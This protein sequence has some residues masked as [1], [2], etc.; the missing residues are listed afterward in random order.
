[1]LIPLMP[2]GLGLGS[3]FNLSV[4]DVKVLSQAPRRGLSDI[5]NEASVSTAA[6]PDLMIFLMG[7]I[8]SNMQC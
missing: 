8:T 7:S 3:R 4:K 2:L 5:P 1:M 6:K